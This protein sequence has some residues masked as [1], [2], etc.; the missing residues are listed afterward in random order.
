[1]GEVSAKSNFRKHTKK[2]AENMLANTLK[3]AG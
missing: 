3:D 1:M 2:H